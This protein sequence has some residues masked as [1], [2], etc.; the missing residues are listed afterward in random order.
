M[1]RLLVDVDDSEEGDNIDEY[2]Q[3]G[4]IIIVLGMNVR[5]FGGRN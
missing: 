5:I 1:H 3:D 2:Q 4:S